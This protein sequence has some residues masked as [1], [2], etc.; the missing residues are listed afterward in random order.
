[1]I[2][3]IALQAA[4]SRYVSVERLEGTGGDWRGLEGTGGD[5]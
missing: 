4:E 5:T 2:E 3:E 1:M